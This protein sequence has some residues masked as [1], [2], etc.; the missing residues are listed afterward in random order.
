MQFKVI[1]PLAPGGDTTAP[2]ARLVLPAVP[3]AP[4]EMGWKDTVKSM[5]GE[6][7]RVIAKFDVPPGTIIPAEYVYHCLRA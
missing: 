7:T 3:P 6:I 5:P 1:N 2:P 4:E